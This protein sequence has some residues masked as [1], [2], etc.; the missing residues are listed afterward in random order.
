MDLYRNSAYAE[1]D[2]EHRAGGSFGVSMFDV[3][4]SAIDLVDPPLPEYVFTQGLTANFDV[5]IDMGDGVRENRIASLDTFGVVP[6]MTETRFRVAGPH[7]LRTLAIPAGTMSRLFEESGLDADAFSAFYATTRPHERA[8]RLLDEMWR[9][10]ERV[11][12]TAN[13]WLDGLTMQFLAVMAETPALSPVGNAPREDVRVRRVLEYVEAHLGE[14]LT[15]AELAAVATLSPAQFS[16]AFK[17]TVGD[18]VWRHVQVRRCERARELLTTTGLPIV[19]V[20]RRCGFAHQSHLTQALGRYC[21][22]TPGQLRRSR[23][24]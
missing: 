10:S 18:T 5:L 2:Q 11:G 6:P 9:A 7:C 12:P 4:Q 23:T 8:A 20:A 22:R 13:L 14:A 3:E 16:R 17:A 1:F 21:G 19:E 15:V 24:L